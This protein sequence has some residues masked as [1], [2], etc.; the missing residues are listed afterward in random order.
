MPPIAYL[1]RI[2]CPLTDAVRVGTGPIAGNNLDP[3]MLTQPLSEAVSL[4]I[5]Q[6]VD[7]RIAFQINKNGPIPAAAAPGPVVNRQDARNGRP[8][9]LAV[10]SAHQPQQRI[11]AGGGYGLTDH[12]SSG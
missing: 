8:V 4:A 10:G 3:G 12:R 7:H 11:G 9:S 5:R 2:R 1:N 6:Q